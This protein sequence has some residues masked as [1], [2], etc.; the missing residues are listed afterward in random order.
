MPF[1]SDLRLIF[2]QRSSNLATSENF[3][4]VV[5]TEARQ[6]RNTLKIT[7]KD[8]FREKSL[9]AEVVVYPKLKVPINNKTNEEK[10]YVWI[11]YE[12][13][14]YYHR[15]YPYPYTPWY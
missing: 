10:N 11:Y 12:N 7:Q 15:P 4:Y 14:T 8:T 6:R 3:R 1:T 5:T 9:D 2:N 13:Y